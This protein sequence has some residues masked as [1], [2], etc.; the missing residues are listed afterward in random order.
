MGNNGYQQSK[1]K[2]TTLDEIEFIE[3]LGLY[4]EK[5]KIM[6]NTNLVRWL[7][8]RVALLQSYVD[9]APFKDWNGLDRESCVQYALDKI[10]E[11]KGYGR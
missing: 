3:R 10:E 4:T 2:H 5:G 8:Y 6:R 7:N 1:D 11:V 9:V